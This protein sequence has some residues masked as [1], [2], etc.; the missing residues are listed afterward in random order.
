[1]KC[2]MIKSIQFNHY[3]KL[4]HLNLSFD[5]K[6]TVISGVNGTCKT[7]LLHIIS[8][9]FQKVNVRCKWIEN[10][11]CG[12]KGM[13]PLNSL[14]VMNPKIERLARGDK[15]YNDP[16]PNHSGI[17]YEV[18][19]ANDRVLKFR[20]HNF[21]ETGRYSVKPPY[22][23]SRKEELPF[24][25][26]IYLG[27]ARLFPFGEFQD[28]K[29]IKNIVGNLPKKYQEEIHDLYYEF[30]HIRIASSNPQHIGT[31]KKRHD[32][33]L[34]PSSSTPH[35]I[36]SNTISAGEESLLILLY[37]L[38]SLKYYYETYKEFY[39]NV[40]GEID[41]FGSI[42]LIDELDATFHPS[43]QSKILQYFLAF[44]KKYAI[45]IIFTT[46]SLSLLESALMKDD[47][48]V[49]YLVDNG[50]VESVEN[51]DIDRIKRNLFEKTRDEVYAS[52]FI[53]I[54]TEDKEARFLI[55]MLF[56]HYKREK[57]EFRAIFDYLCLIDINV[58]V[59]TLINLFMCKCP[60]KSTGRMRS[61]MNGI[62]IVDGDV[63]EIKRK[64]IKDNNCNILIFFG[65][66]SPERFIWKYANELL[67][68][69]NFLSD[70]FVKNEGITKALYTDFIEKAPKVEDDRNIW[71]KYFNDNVTFNKIIFDWWLRDKNNKGVIDQFYDAFKVRFK[72]TASSCGINPHEFEILA[73]SNQ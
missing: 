5:K 58:G 57:S 8:N 69:G 50:N 44:A 40:D 7:S 49:I 59:D 51:P 17:L 45:Q 43:Y 23:G 20:R 63:N 16:A 47:C 14:N 22:G 71:K 13:T 3:K 38:I 11:E 36:D 62:C 1:M 72:R 41:H 42:L 32:F 19:Y 31:I 55:N 54:F 68:N 67:D 15:K 18:T 60:I 35:G 25:P 48:K 30:T 37:A 39:D 70:E 52:K 9:S 53:P 6:I 29:S 2:Y 34:E 21:K 46:H 12:T 66:E 61:V 4:K 26:V 28:D 73:D 24:C 56:E 10:S 64:E 33:I 27:L 65:N